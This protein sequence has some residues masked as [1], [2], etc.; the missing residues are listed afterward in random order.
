MHTR[1]K[2]QGK[3]EAIHMKA[4]LARDE[5]SLRVRTALEEVLEAEMTEA[6]G[7]EKANGGLIIKP[8]R[9]HTLAKNTMVTNLECD[10]S[11]IQNDNPPTGKSLELPVS[12]GM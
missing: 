1:S 6:L 9:I 8:L 11:E 3:S 5:E 4:L 10:G 7:A 2:R 12:S